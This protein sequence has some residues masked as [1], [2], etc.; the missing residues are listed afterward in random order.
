VRRACLWWCTF[1]G[2]ERIAARARAIG[3]LLGFG[4]AVSYNPKRSAPLV[5]A[6][7]LDAIVLETDCPYLTPHPR[8]N[9][10]NEPSNIPVIARWIAEYLE[11][12]PE[13][14]GARSDENAIR[15]FGIPA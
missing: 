11:T 8:R 1:S 14:V 5:R 12:D 4:G 9:D 15:L 3:F 13:V 10:R 7:G 2:D 6:V